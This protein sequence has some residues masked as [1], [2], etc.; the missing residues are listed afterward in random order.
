MEWQLYNKPT[1]S[2]TVKQILFNRGIDV[3]DIEHYIN[4]TDEDICS[5]KLLERN[6]NLEK[7]AKT[8]I[9][10]I[11]KNKNILVIVDSDCDGFTSS[12]TLLNYLYKIA[13]TFTTNNIDYVFHEGKGHGLKEF[14]DLCLEY[15][16]VICPDS[17]SNDYD[18][19][20]RLAEAGIP[21]IVLDHHEADKLSENAII[22]NNQLCSYP[23]KALSGVGVVWQF[24]RYLDKVNHTH[25]AE[26]FYDLVA[27][28]D[29]GDMMDLRSPETRRLVTKGFLPEN[30]HNPFI[31][32]MWQ[33]NKFKLTDNPTAWGATFYIVPMINACNRSGSQE[34]KKTMFEAMLTF[35]AFNK[36]PSTKRGHKQGDMETIL[37]QALRIATN[38][39]NHQDKA[40]KVNME[41]LEERIQDKNLL[42]NKVLLFLIEPNEIASG[43]AGLVAN[44][45]MGKYQRPCCVLTHDIKNDKYAGSARGCDNIGIDNFKDMCKE[46]GCCEYAEGHQSAFGVSVA[47]SNID[48]FITATN[49]M[50]EGMRTDPIYNIDYL[51]GE[52]QVDGQRIL[53]IADMGYLWGSNVPES[54]VGIEAVTVTDKNVQIMGEKRD[55]LKVTLPNGVCIIK[56]FATED[57]INDFT[58]APGQEKHINIVGTCNK[59]EWNGNVTPQIFMTDYEIVKSSQGWIF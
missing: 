50:L 55:T 43:I 31:Y 20:K 6:H 33:K 4:L 1:F 2:S 19:H 45:M 57:E 14:I 39:K 15:D 34:D 7:A 40:V 16:L 29:T 23:N 21:V 44:K 12:A 10:A 24:C 52:N 8:I 54:K 17:A 41:M 26:E 47:A 58:V 9:S 56:F 42:D 13:P 22:I 30:I 25:Y 37:D 28:G 18:E 38:V 51:W 32:G 27:L 3:D 46:S 36:V 5:F 35:K 59:N 48:N 11:A 49:N 53:D